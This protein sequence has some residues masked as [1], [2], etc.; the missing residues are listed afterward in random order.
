MALCHDIY[1][2]SHEFGQGPGQAPFTS[3]IAAFKKPLA[4]T[5]LEFERLLWQQLQYIHE[6][7][8]DHFGWDT[9]VSKD[10]NDAKFSFS[11]GG[12]A[13]FV[14]GLHLAASRL[15]RVMD[16]PCMVFNPHEQFEALRLNGS[17]G[18]LQQAIRQRDMA[19]QGSINPVLSN[20][21][22]ASESRQYS[23]RSVSSQWQCPFHQRSITHERK[24]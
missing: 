23:G 2:F 3:F 13:F 10:P 19:Y 11:V 24:S 17:Y 5:E 21:G 1:E 6:I 7:D 16:V 12:R 15:A 9:S 20:F 4:L 18:K 22:D 14:I 8:A